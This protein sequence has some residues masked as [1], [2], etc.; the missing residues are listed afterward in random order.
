MT[1][2]A[3][4]RLD[5]G[6][7]RCERLTR[8]HADELIPLLQDPRVAA[9]LAAS[10]QPLSEEE[11]EDR[12][13]GG[14][15]H[16]ERSGFGLWVLRDRATGEVVGRGGLQHTFVAGTDEIE[17]AWAILPAR[18]GEGLATEFAEATVGVAFGELHLPDVVA[19]TLPGNLASRK[20]ME[21]VG[22]TYER[23]LLHAGLTHVLYRCLPA[24]R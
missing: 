20:V 3:P 2:W 19:F 21:K 9:T 16:W 10:G 14:I 13:A 12:V 7:L 24:S 6:R 8:E 17:A 18:W 11:I 15:E 4:E 23:E 22:F 1:A 5:T